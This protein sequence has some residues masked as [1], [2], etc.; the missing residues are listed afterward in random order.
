[1]EELRFRFDLKDLLEF[2]LVNERCNRNGVLC[3][4]AFEPRIFKVHVLANGIRG[5][6][7]DEVQAIGVSPEHFV[8]T[9]GHTGVLRRAMLGIM[10]R[11][12]K[13]M[14]QRVLD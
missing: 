3:F 11:C 4:V 12:S 13:L 7:V 6:I 2:A 8:E 14:D 1:M 5:R 9:L 10:D